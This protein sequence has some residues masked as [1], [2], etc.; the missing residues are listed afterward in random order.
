MRRS[1]PLV[2]ST[3]LLLSLGLAAQTRVVPPI[4]DGFDGNSMSP[5][6]FIYS[7]VRTQQVWQ[8]AAIARTAAVIQ[9]FAFRADAPST[10][11]QAWKMYA[12][13]V[14]LGPTSASPA[15]LATNFAANRTA[16]MTTVFQGDLDL[17]AQVPPQAPAAPFNVT[18]KIATPFLYQVVQG[19][20]LMEFASAPANPTKTGYYADAVGIGGAI[21]LFGSNGRPGGGD[22]LALVGEKPLG[23]VPGGSVALTTATILKTYPGALFLGSS[24]RNWNALPLPFDLTGAGAPGNWLYTG[25]EFLLPHSWQQVNGRWASTAL[26]SVP[27]DARLTGATVFAQ[28]FLVDPT[29]NQFGVVFSRGLALGI[30]SAGDQVSAQVGTHDPLAQD[31]WYALG[32]GAAGGAVVEFAGVFG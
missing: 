26:L 6:P 20:L 5:F 23:L 1:Y 16:A 10:P 27:N 11:M 19:N 18:F 32:T 25:I 8:A 2:P 13:T 12:L 28:S 14:T 22:T 24:N 17:P 7:T 9:G 29:A 3:L 21:T 4:A 30:G 15:T 31:G